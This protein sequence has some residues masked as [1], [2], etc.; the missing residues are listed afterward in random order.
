[1]ERPVYP[2]AGDPA[3]NLTGGPA[4]ATAATLAALGRPIL[5]HLD[6]AFG[7]LYQRTAELLRRAFGT[8]QSPVILQGEAVAGLEAAA[9]S[10]IGPGDVV[11]NLVSGDVRPRLRRLGTP[12]RPGGRR[13][14]REDRA[15]GRGGVDRGNGRAGGVGMLCRPGAMPGR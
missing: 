2:A 13:G 15:G 6:P 5:H 12:V 8:S 11:L 10:L 3:F 1:V 4:G 7:A 9:A 14:S